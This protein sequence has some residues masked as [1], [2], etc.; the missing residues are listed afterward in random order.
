MH[1]ITCKSESGFTTT[2]AH[3][4]ASLADVYAVPPQSPTCNSL[5]SFF[6]AIFYTRFALYNFVSIH[7]NSHAS[8]T[9]YQNRVAM[10]LQNKGTWL[11]STLLA[12][13]LLFGAAALRRPGPFPCWSAYIVTVGGVPGI[14]GSLT[15]FFPT[16]SPVRQFA[17]TAFSVRALA[18]GFLLLRGARGSAGGST[19]G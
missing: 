17:L 6:T 15:P 19:A 14:A 11:R 8:G 16:L 1:S 2:I 18:V 12:A 10:Q 5:F 4:I 9:L 13:A 7:L 3:P